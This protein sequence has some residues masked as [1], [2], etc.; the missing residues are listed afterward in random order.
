MCS[1]RWQRVDIWGWDVVSSFQMLSPVFKP[2]F[3]SSSPSRHFPRTWSS[4]E[5]SPPRIAAASTNIFDFLLTNIL[6][7]LKYVGHMF[8]LTFWL[9]AFFCSWVKSTGH[10]VNVLQNYENYAN[11][12]L[13]SKVKISPFVKLLFLWNSPLCWKFLLKECQVLDQNQFSSPAAVGKSCF[14]YIKASTNF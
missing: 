7:S 9:T 2:I 6:D 8:E 3:T 11:F 14:C 1:R 10:F 4:W 13:L 12:V 5:E